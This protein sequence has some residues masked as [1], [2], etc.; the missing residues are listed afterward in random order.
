[1]VN[2]ESKIGKR[3]GRL[4]VVEK[5]EE[6]YRKGKCCETLWRCKC[7]CGGEKLVRTGQITREEVT[8]CGCRGTGKER[9]DSIIGE[10]IGVLKVISF[11]HRGKTREQYYNCECQCGSIVKIRREKIKKY[12]GCDACRWNDMGDLTGGYWGRV[13]TNAKIRNLE[14]TVTQEE[15]WEQFLKQEGKCALSGLDLILSRVHTGGNT[16]SLDRID[17]CNGYTKDNIQWLHKDIN[18]MKWKYDETYFIELCKK[19]VRKKG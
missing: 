7:D 16:A 14:V 15:A 10:K 19:V 3:I 4:V 2:K 6:R 18:R 8:S 5:T 11:S 17:N 1:M 12:K 13:L 9:D